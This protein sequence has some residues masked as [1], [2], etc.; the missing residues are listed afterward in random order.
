MIENNTVVEAL[1]CVDVQL[2]NIAYIPTATVHAIGKRLF[3]GEIQK[4]LDMTYR[5]YDYNQAQEVKKIVHRLEKLEKSSIL[6]NQ[7]GGTMKKQ[8]L[9]VGASLK[10]GNR[11]VNALTRGTINALIDKYEEVEIKILSYTVKNDV[12]NIVETSKGDIEIEEI[13]CNPWQG[14]HV[15]GR[16]FFKK[17]VPNS[18]FDKWIKKY[19]NIYQLIK[20]AD[21]VL[22]ISEGDSFSDIYGMKRFIIHSSIKIAS[23]Q[24]QK[25]IV[26]LPQTMGPFKNP[27]VRRIAKYI[28]AHVNRNFVR[29]MLSYDILTK[30][31]CIDSKKV[32]YSPDMAFYMK[33]NSNISLNQVCPNIKDDNSKIIGLNVSGLL[34]NGGYSRNNMFNFKVDYIELIDSII[35]FFMKKQDTKI[36]LVPHVIVA[37]MPVED[38]LATCRTIFNKFKEQYKDRIYIVDKPYREDELKKLI[39]ECDF[40]IGGRMHACIGAISTTV[41]TVPIAYSR[42]FIGIWKEF[43]LGNCV[44]DPRENNKKELIDIIEKNYTEKEKIKEILESKTRNIKQD[45]INMFDNI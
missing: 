31:L 34:Y 1:H 40:F 36:L 32:T 13:P 17:V 24:L 38:D 9:L 2:G 14:L 6:Y 26:L 16:S 37:D 45:V 7:I 15:C 18:I 33:P 41:P 29:D 3:I 39:G 35:H 22:D 30:D 11:G 28:T 42:K 23:I 27:V 19:K 43:G 12:V 44:A 8:I 5:V 10:S 25:N 21:L 20:R 4:N